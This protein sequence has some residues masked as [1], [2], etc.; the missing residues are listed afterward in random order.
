[1]L[2]TDT[3]NVS[4]AQAAPTEANPSCQAPTV[5]EE[6]LKMGFDSLVINEASKRLGT[7]SHVKCNIL[8]RFP[9]RFSQMNC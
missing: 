4:S 7:L 6:L 1:L 3:V 5:Q 8:R 2:L 9:N